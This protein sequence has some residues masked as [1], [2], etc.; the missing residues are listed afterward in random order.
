[1]TIA[2]QIADECLNEDPVT[3]LTRK[4]DR[5]KREHE[6]CQRAADDY[7]REMERLNWLLAHAEGARRE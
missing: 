6:R 3:I 4:R 2:E 5:A 1:M 7:K